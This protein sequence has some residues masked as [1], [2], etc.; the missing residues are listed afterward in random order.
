MTRAK[1]YFFLL[2]AFFGVFLHCPNTSMG[3]S[4]TETENSSESRHGAHLD[5]DGW[6][7]FVVYSPDATA[8]NL[9]LFDPPD[10]KTPQ[11]NVPLVKAGDDWKIKIRGDGIGP[12][13]LYMYQAKGPHEIK[14]DDT[15]GL[16]FNEQ[17]FLGDP[18]AH[19][20]Q[21]V[22]FSAL[23]SAVPHTDTTSPVY[24]G[25]GKSIVY[26]HCKDAS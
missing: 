10:S 17:Y 3:F 14:K 20:T 6:V 8:V 12:G 1:A 15:Y 18:F 5:N 25:G 9:L 19:K 21:N 13:L 16:M 23:F 4:V 2:S 11:H 24:A 7:H 26:D 22:T